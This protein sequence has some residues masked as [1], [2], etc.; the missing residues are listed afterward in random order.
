MGLGHLVTGE[1]QGTQHPGMEREASF[2]RRGRREAALED[3][4]GQEP[5]PR[6]VNVKKQKVIYVKSRH[7]VPRESRR[8]FSKRDIPGTYFRISH[9]FR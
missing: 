1:L 4:P 3:Q 2:R 5:K 6:V 9:A 7:Q 8:V